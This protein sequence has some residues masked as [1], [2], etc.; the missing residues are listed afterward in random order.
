MFHSRRFKTQWEYFKWNE[1]AI[2]ENKS[3][4]GIRIKTWLF[5]FG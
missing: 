3:Y 2:E 5:I 1:E 4:H